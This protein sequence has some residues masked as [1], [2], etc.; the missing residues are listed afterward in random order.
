M[1]LSVGIDLA[2]VASVDDALRDF[3]E[4]YLERVYTTREV[5]DCRVGSTLS[6]TRLAA[7]FAV[8]EAAF[9]ALRVPRDCAVPWRTVELVNG[10][11]GAPELRLTGE[12]ADLAA[13]GGIV[14]LSVSLTHEGPFAAAV[15]LATLDR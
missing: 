6:A 13:A 15:V 7:R 12:A 14:E 2:S 11:S 4:R 8:K 1:G 10:P 3:G 5:E 9:K